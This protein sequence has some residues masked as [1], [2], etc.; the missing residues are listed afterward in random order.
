MSDTA[1]AEMLLHYDHALATCR[2]SRAAVLELLRADRSG[3][4]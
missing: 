3:R 2:A 1:L 4:A